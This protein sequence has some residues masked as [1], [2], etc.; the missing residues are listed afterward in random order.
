[1]TVDP[2]PSMDHVLLEMAEAMSRR[3]TCG[4]ARVGVVVALDGRVCST[5]YNG[6]PAGI[7]HCRH[8]V[9]ERSADRPADAPACATAVHAEANAVSFAAR[10]GVALAGA[11]LYTTLSPC[12]P[13]AQLVINAG[14]TRVVYA[15]GYRSTDGLRLLEE[16][17][18]LV[19]SIDDLAQETL[20]EPGRRKDSPG[21]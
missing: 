19:Q 16:A 13:C 10:H 14:I 18:L 21:R 3:G 17:N 9:D 20:V 6:A 5:G 12:V 1:M 4:R 11:T 2:R 8:P 15:V 7:G